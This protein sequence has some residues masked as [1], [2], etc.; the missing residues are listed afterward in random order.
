MLLIF[1]LRTF[2]DGSLLV[3]EELDLVLVGRTL[4]LCVAGRRSYLL[5]SKL[6]LILLA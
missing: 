1:L 3:L 2:W 4:F 5:L 6:A